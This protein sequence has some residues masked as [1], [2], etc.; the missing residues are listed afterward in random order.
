MLVG[1][2]SVILEY[3]VVMADIPTLFGPKID[4]PV[5]VK[6]IGHSPTNLTVNLSK[7]MNNIEDS[8]FIS[9]HDDKNDCL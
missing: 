4:K 6:E 3:R 2:S 5:K 8:E 7:L 9:E 1:V